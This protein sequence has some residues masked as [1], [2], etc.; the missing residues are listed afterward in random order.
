MRRIGVIGDVHARHRR[1]GEALDWLSGQSLDVLLCTGDLADGEGCIDSSVELLRQAGVRCVA[2][3][4]DRWLLTDRVRH[5][6]KAHHRSEVNESTLDYLGS[7][8]K[9]LEIDTLLGPLL[10]CHGVAEDDLGKVWPGTARSPIER[11]TD[12]DALIA[13]RHHRFMINGHL[14]YRVLIDFEHLLLMNA[15]TLDGQRAGVSIIDFEAQS[16]S[17][18]E[19][20]AV[21][22]G[23]P[24]RVAEHP[25]AGHSRQT[26]KD[27]Q[28]FDGQWQPV[29]LYAADGG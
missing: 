15:G 28:A 10:L 13:Q 20:D 27:S 14:H 8:P 26:W 2:G 22:T 29:T 6:A 18:H 23:A 1:L 25:I 12:I 5:V 11:N 16:I 3:N 7:L 17:A 24:V 21:G 9:T 19:L 4:H